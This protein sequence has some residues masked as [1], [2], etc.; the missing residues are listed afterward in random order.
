MSLMHAPRMLLGTFSLFVSFQHWWKKVAHTRLPSVGF[1]SWCRF[2]AVS[3][4]VTWVIIPAVGCHYF[5]QPLR[6]MLPILLLG[7]RGTMGV[8]SLPKTDTRQRR[9]CD[10]NPG[11]SAP[12]SS[13]LTTRLPALENWCKGC[14]TLDITVA[15]DQKNENGT[16]RPDCS[17]HTD[18]FIVFARWR[19]CALPSST[20]FRHLTSHSFHLVFLTYFLL[21]FSAGCPHVLEN[22]WKSLKKSYQFFHGFLSRTTWVGLSKFGLKRYCSDCLQSKTLV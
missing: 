20:F 16:T 14:S 13:T 9:G 18:P 2:L 22:Y 8:N 3:L 21:F 1:R 11:P 7:E 15:E 4:Q 5:P 12:E 6:G 19:Q 17:H 10:L